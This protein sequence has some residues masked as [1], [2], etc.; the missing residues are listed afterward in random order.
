MPFYVRR[1]KKNGKWCYSVVNRK[2]RR[3]HSKCSTRKNAL[4]QLR[5]LRAII[6]NKNFKI[7]PKS[8]IKPRTR[9]RRRRITKKV[10]P[11]KK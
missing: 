9:R 11:L 10:M 2:S 5:L 1:S 3:V 7:R 6:Y 8:E 4:S